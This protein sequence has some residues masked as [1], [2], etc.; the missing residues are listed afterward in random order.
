M[1]GLIVVLAS[2]GAAPLAC[3]A[4]DGEPVQAPYVEKGDCWSYR[5]SNFRD[6]GKLRDADEYEICVSFVDKANGTILGVQTFKSD[7]RENDLTYTAE[8]GNARSGSGATNS[9]PARFLRFPLHAGDSYRLEYETRNP[10]AARKLQA[11]HRW[12]LKVVG[13]EDV[14]VPAGTFRALKIEGKGS[15]DRLDSGLRGDES[16]T[17]WYAPEVARWVKF[18]QWDQHSNG[19]QVSTSELT[20]FRLNK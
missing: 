7:G 19:G 12:D 3:L 15:Y 16:V 13:W 18:E 10:R 8:W 20:S 14:T 5:A 9:P 6:Q 17:Y 11:R 4:A 2:L 1:R